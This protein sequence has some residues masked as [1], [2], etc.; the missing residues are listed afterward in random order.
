MA[1]CEPT[2]VGVRVSVLLG[3]LFVSVIYGV[4]YECYILGCL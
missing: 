2:P 1:A 4:I 3:V